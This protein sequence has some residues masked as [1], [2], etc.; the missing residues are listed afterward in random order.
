M[1]RFLIL[2]LIIVAFVLPAVPS[3][4]AMQEDD[5]EYIDT[6]KDV[7]FWVSWDVEQP[8][9]QF[10]APDGA[11]YDPKIANPNTTTINADKSFYYVV[12]AAPAGQWRVK[13]DKGKNSEIEIS[14]HDYN[15]GLSINY[16]TLEAIKDTELPVKFSVAGA[17]NTYFSYRISAVIDHTGEEKLLAEG[18]AYVGGEEQRTL[19]LD[20]LSSYTAYMLKLYVWY[21]DNGT[22]VFD[23]AFSDPFAYTNPKV[24]KDKKDF[25]MTVLPEDKLIDVEWNEL[26]YGI[27]SVVVALFEDDAKEPAF[28][29]EYDVRKTKSVQLSYDPKAA[30]VSVEFTPKK[31]GLSLVTNKKSADLSKFA[32][33]LPD[34]EGYNSLV[35]P[36]KYDGLKKQHVGVTVND[37]TTELILDGK[38]SVNI[39]LGSEWNTL[40]VEYQD[41]N[42]VYWKIDRSVFV[43]TTAPTL[44]MNRTYDGMTVDDKKISIGGIASDCNAVK[45][46]GESVKIDKT[47]AF[48]K[49]VEL[50]NGENTIEVV[51]TD[52]VGNASRYTAVV[53]RGFA[54]SDAQE[55]KTINTTQKPGGLFDKLT[56]YGSY[57]ILIA[58]SVVCVLVIGYVLL[59]WRK[60]GKK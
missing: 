22:D 5:L 38:G 11:I 26:E 6:Q 43:D 34:G 18:S 44:S 29:D 46:N 48:S 31:D 15:A 60:G 3:Y 21:D 13:Y 52:A 37:R 25:K 53:T 39:T 19:W 56:A 41:S 58:V 49:D 2:I 36:M 54:G 28:F 20:D 1:K 27:D 33:K 14:V 40:K 35:M 59:F 42:T 57:W 30:K 8:Q 51:A 16:F 7:V 32:V 47:G 10:V 4:A 9:V 55:E 12:K 17:E 24:D 23:F 45:I 50:K